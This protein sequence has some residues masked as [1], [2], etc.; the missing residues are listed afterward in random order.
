MAKPL[1]EDLRERVIAAIVDG[2]SRH[3][4][5]AHFAVSVSSAIRWYARYEQTGSVAAKRRGGDHRSHAVEAHAGSLLAWWSEKPDITL[6]ELR[7][8]LAE[9]GKTASLST[10]WRFFDRRQI[11]FKKSRSMPASSTVRTS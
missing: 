8:K 3:Q 4:A 7:G 5:A 6:E 10:I 2:M 9:E 1:S 11:T